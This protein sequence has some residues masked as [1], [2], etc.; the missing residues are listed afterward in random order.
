MQQNAVC[1]KSSKGFQCE[2]KSQLGEKVPLPADDL[3]SMWGLKF[4]VR[5]AVT[6]YLS[7]VS[8]RGNAVVIMQGKAYIKAKAHK[9]RP[10]RERRFKETPDR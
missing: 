1:I 8:V 6:Y 4:F 7:A 9:C 10:A 3:T 2:I 5:E